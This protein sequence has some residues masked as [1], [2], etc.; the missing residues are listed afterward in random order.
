MN[1]DDMD[2]L[3]NEYYMFLSPGWQV[4]MATMLER[5]QEDSSKLSFGNYTSDR[6]RMQAEGR[7]QLYKYIMD[8]QAGV[9]GAYEAFQEEQRQ[10]QE[11]KPEEEGGDF[12]VHYEAAQ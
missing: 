12:G 1:D 3:R 10:A 9:R 7:C 2:A 8:H 5:F 6:D 11:A 4:F